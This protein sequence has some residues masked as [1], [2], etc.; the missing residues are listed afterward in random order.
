MIEMEQKVESLE[1]VLQDFI[2]HSIW[3]NNEQNEHFDRMQQEMHEFKDEMREFK[4]NIAMDT[5]K[6]KASLDAQNAVL[7]KKMGDLT[8]KLGTVIEDIIAPG[9]P[10]ALEKKFGSP[11]LTMTTRLK[12]K[13][14]M[15][16]AEEFDVVSETEDGRI[17]L[18]EVKNSAT[19]QHVDEVLIKAEKLQMM[20]YPGKQ[21]TGI[22]GTLN[23]HET[24][25]KYASRMGVWIIGMRGDYLEILN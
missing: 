24:I 21:V 7:N 5:A 10:D 15:G 25:L 3:L 9:T 13:D 19:P 14:G 22:L 16:N 20:R 17:Y 8:N 2:R 18:L 23:P 6:L 1:Q 4:E 11:V 12:I